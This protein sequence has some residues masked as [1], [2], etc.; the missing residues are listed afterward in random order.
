M[1]AKEVRPERF[2]TFSTS[3]SLSPVQVI[4]KADSLVL[5][6]LRLGR[7]DDD[8][9]SLVSVIGEVEWG[10]RDI[11]PGSLMAYKSDLASDKNSRSKL[12]PGLE[13]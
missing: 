12:A 8:E 7:D 11:A 9:N 4:F 1:H 2:D 10:C 6:L 5:D 13:F 3:K